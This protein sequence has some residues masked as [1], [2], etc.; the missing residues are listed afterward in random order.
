MAVFLIVL[1]VVVKWN[2]T[3]Q[4]LMYSSQVL[5]KSH[6]C[7]YTQLQ[8]WSTLPELLNAFFSSSFQILPPEAA[9]YI[10]LSIWWK[11]LKQIYAQ[12][13]SGEHPQ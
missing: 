7:S 11:I 12:P 5:E 2:F 3:T 8:Y 9:I 4:P 6:C 13:L 10:Q 1:F